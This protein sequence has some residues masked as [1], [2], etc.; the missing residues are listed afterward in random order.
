MAVV[1]LIVLFVQIVLRVLAS[2]IKA[3]ISLLGASLLAIAG[4]VLAGF[5]IVSALGALGLIRRKRPRS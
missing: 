3:G 5:L 1:H 4:V 2:T